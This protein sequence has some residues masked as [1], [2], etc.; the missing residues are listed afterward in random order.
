MDGTFRKFGISV[1]ILLH[2]TPWLFDRNEQS[3]AKK[4]NQL[5]EVFGSNVNLKRLLERFPTLLKCNVQKTIIPNY[6][7][8]SITGQIFSYEKIES[9]IVST[10][11][12]NTLESFFF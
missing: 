7:V 2:K 8:K 6:Q 12:N 1:D 3:M 4:L 5:D 10:N 9:T 11:S